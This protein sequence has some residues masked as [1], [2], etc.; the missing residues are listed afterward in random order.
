MNKYLGN[1]K[2]FVR[3]K[4]YTIL[5]TKKENLIFINFCMH[6]FTKKFIIPTYALL[7]IIQFLSKIFFN[8]IKNKQDMIK[9]FLPT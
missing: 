2:S 7:K 1:L 4:S 6:Q 5:I 9:L 3:N 8:I